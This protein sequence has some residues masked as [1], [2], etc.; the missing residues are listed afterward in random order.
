MRKVLHCDNDDDDDHDNIS[1]R[2][3]AMECIKLLVYCV[4]IK[5]SMVLCEKDKTVVGGAC[6]SLLG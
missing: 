5:P 1:Q 6:K 2:E 4:S 3:R